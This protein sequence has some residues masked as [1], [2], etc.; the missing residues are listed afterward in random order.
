M[1]N[2]ILSFNIDKDERRTV[3][4]ASLFLIELPQ[5]SLYCSIYLS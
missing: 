4:T 2:G 5:L 3:L 1:R